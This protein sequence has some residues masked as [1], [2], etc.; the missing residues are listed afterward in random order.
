MIKGF[1]SRRTFQ[2]VPYEAEIGIQFACGDNNAIIANTTNLSPEGVRFFVPKGQIK[3]APEEIIELS[4]KLPNNKAFTVQGEICYF[5]NAMDSNEKPVVYYG[6]RFINLTPEI[7]D[8]LREF[9]QIQL[10]SETANAPE[11]HP[12]AVAPDVTAD[13]FDPET[14]D[15]A[16][17]DIP[18]DIFPG[19]PGLS[20]TAAIAEPTVHPAEP[21]AQPGLADNPLTAR[22]DNSYRSLSQEMIDQLIRSLTAAQNQT[23]AP[24]ASAS[25]KKS[26]EH[27]VKK[28]PVPSPQAAEATEEVAPSAATRNEL[29]SQTDKSSNFLE[30]IRK[31][32]ESFNI[33]LDPEFFEKYITADDKSVDT[34]ST[35]QPV[36]TAHSD[37]ELK[38]NFDSLAQEHPPKEPGLSDSLP[39]QVSSASSSRNDNLLLSNSELIDL[40]YGNETNPKK[41]AGAVTPSVSPVEPKPAEPLKP[42]A[43]EPL[44]S[45]F[46]ISR[47][48]QISKPEP[49]LE[50]KIPSGPETSHSGSQITGG[51]DPIQPQVDNTLFTQGNDPFN[52]HSVPKK[53]SNAPMDQRMIDQIVQAMLKRKK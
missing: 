47:F 22:S 41:E 42:A 35:A 23:S 34:P 40:L 30:Q 45:G 26:D 24:A 7:S 44:I 2:R 20:E 4:F 39:H 16:E 38:F 50:S 43:D 8:A 32:A 36:Q 25:E 19:H 21:V 15:P 49:T 12:T 53:P 11:P 33:K 28:Q 1:I 14:M 6:V 51:L 48:D 52:I 9:C 18:E 17:F 37:T 5:S 31:I 46:G 27:V 10:N 13:T 3:L 29:L